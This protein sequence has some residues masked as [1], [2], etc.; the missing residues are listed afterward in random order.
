M[1]EWQ[2]LFGN[3]KRQ[4]AG[5]FSHKKETPLEQEEAQLLKDNQEKEAQEAE[6]RR[7]DK[8]DAQRK[9][10]KDARQKQQEVNKSPVGE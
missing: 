10:E 9:K 7:Q 2:V 8:K 3:M 5:W 1:E 4:I 6:L